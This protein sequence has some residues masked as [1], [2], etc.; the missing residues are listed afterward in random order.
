LHTQVFNFVNTPIW[1]QPLSLC[2]R[3]GC[4]AAARQPERR[5]LLIDK[6]YLILDH[7][8]YWANDDSFC[9]MCSL[10]IDGFNGV[11]P[12]VTQRANFVIASRAPLDKRRSFK[13]RRPY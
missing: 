7:L 5:R 9:P 10:W 1:L 4:G 13:A 12:H 11:G 2:P 8:M 3:G 6:P